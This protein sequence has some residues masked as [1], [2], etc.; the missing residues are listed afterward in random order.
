MLATCLPRHWKQYNTASFC[1]ELT[2]LRRYLSSCSWIFCLCVWEEFVQPRVLAPRWRT[3]WRSPAQLCA[4]SSCWSVP[5]ASCSG[6]RS[7]CCVAVLPSCSGSLLRLPKYRWEFPFRHFSKN[8]PPRTVHFTSQ[9]LGVKVMSRS[10]HPAV[11]ISSFQPPHLHHEH[12]LHRLCSDLLY[13]RA[14]R[15][16]PRHGQLVTTTLS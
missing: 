10:C 8:K 9:H 11:P 1:R 15:L 13:T 16:A 7:S 4:Q 3:S 5:S 2:N 14:D 12:W 6:S